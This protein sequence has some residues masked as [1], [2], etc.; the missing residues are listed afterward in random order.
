[1]PLWMKIFL[2][3]GPIVAFFCF[4][5]LAT[6]PIPKRTIRVGEQTCDVEFVVT[7]TSCTSTGGCTDQGYDKAVCPA[8][9]PNQP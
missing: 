4:Y 5:Q 8:G 6:R 1:M 7:G 9:V 2:V 3:V